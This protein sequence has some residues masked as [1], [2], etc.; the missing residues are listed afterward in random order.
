MTNAQDIKKRILEE[1][2]E[3][4][5]NIEHAR[6]AKWQKYLHSL[7]LKNKDGSLTISKERVIHWEKEIAT[8]YYELTE[9]LKEYDREETRNY[10]PLLEKALDQMAEEASEAVINEKVNEMFFVNE[11]KKIGVPKEKILEILTYWQG[12]NKD[13]QQA[14]EKRRLFLGEKTV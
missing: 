12:F 5:A 11:A 3:K 8:P 6:W 10:L 1:F 2:I 14:K 7:C 9:K 4:G 13:I